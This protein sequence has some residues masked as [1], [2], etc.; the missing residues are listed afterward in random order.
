MQY[1]DN[2]LDM[3]QDF[4]IL[5]SLSENESA[6]TAWMYELDAIADHFTQY[7]E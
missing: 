2:Y 5:N 3:E 6:M 1:D 7:Y 4:E